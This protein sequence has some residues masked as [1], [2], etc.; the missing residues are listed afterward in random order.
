MTTADGFG[1]VNA[2]FGRDPVYNSA[3]NGI[4]VGYD[5]SQFISEKAFQQVQ[6][7]MHGNAQRYGCMVGGWLAY[8]SFVLL[9]Q[10]AAAV[11]VLQLDGSKFR[12]YFCCLWTK[13]H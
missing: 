13:V 10:M 1:D 7:R 5:T 8:N 11:A 9:C 4:E 2:A 6:I 12:F 3:A